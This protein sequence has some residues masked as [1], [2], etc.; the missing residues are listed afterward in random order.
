MGKIIIDEND[1]TEF[2]ESK[3]SC[4][5]CTEMNS[6]NKDWDTIKNSTPTVG[7]LNTANRLK[8]VIE[9]IEKRENT[10]LKNDSKKKKS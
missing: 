5:I 3:C 7:K 8:R 1:K 9:K 2:T 10:K 6:A 4:E